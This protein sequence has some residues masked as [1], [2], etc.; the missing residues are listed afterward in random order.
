MRYDKN[1]NVFMLIIIVASLRQVSI[2]DGLGSPAKK[3][4]SINKLVQ[5]HKN[6]DLVRALL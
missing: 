3:P 2:K 5:L 6:T 4:I 1:N